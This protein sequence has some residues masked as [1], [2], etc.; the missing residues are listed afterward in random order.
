MIFLDFGISRF[1]KE[2]VGEVSFTRF[3]G[4]LCHTSP[5]MK[6]AYYLDK[7]MWVDLYYNDL[8]GLQRL[9]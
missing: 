6:K 4:T 1:V 3:V 9:Y 2:N 7:A 5:Q 8:W